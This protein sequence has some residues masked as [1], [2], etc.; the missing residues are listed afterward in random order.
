[1]KKTTERLLSAGL[2]R[3]IPVRIGREESLLHMD[4]FQGR[5]NCK[6]IQWANGKPTIDLSR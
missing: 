4:I 1:M 2:I 5:T 6:L 3:M